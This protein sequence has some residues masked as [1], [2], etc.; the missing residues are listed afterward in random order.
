[1]MAI[2]STR[3]ISLKIHGTKEFMKI[4][5]ME[6]GLFTCHQFIQQIFNKYP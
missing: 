6:I 3:F 2:M 5:F 4:L 1:M